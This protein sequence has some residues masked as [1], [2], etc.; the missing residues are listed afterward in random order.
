[1]PPTR[2][3]IVHR[4]IARRVEKSARRTR[5]ACDRGHVDGADGGRARESTSDAPR[6]MMGRGEWGQGAH[7]GARGGLTLPAPAVGL[8]TRP[9]ASQSIGAG[10]PRRGSRRAFAVAI[11]SAEFGQVQTVTFTFTLICHLGKTHSHRSRGDPSWGAQ[12][13]N[14]YTKFETAIVPISSRPERGGGCIVA[15]CCL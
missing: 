6:L 4:K 10:A 8:W 11:E 9:Q 7:K 15:F 1:M 2:K 12:I 3:K 13:S 14:R 5:E